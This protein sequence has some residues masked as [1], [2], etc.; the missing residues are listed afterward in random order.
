MKLEAQVEG[1]TLE[2]KKTFEV[3][4]RTFSSEGHPSSQ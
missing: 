1:L 4:R 2:M 3:S